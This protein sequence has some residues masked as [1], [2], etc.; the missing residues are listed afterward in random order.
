MLYFKFLKK[1]VCESALEKK[2]Q[3]VPINK[4]HLPKRYAQA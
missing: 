4:Q 2:V 1:L 3:E